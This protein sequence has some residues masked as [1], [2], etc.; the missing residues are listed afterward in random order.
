MYINLRS[1]LKRLQ[2]MARVKMEEGSG[3]AGI[4]GR[5]GNLVF[6]MSADGNTYLQQAAAGKKR[7]GSEAQQQYR[8]IF[9]V[10]AR[11]GREQ[12]ASAEGRAYYQPFVQPGRFGSVYRTALA[13]F[14]KPPQLLAVE[15]NGYQGQMGEHLRAQAYKPCGVTSVKVQVLD[16]TRQVLEE[17]EAEPIGDNWWAYRTQQAHPAAA[18]QQLRVLAY[19]RPGNEA[20]LVV[21]LG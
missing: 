18:A 9:G 21:N 10:A 14:T 7:P 19:D 20:E 1:A 2:D 17:G 6:R 4:S 15:A 13:D 8:R 11:Y 5:V 3:I 12:Q 16:A